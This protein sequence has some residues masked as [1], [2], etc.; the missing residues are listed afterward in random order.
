VTVPVVVNDAATTDPVV[1]KP[2]A[3]L[4][5]SRTVTMLVTDVVDVTA[6]RTGKQNSAQ[7][8]NISSRFMC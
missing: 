8:G 7:N 1:V 3:V 2:G 4:L 5:V 6:P